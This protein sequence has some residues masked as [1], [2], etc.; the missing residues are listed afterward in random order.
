MISLRLLHAAEFAQLLPA[1]LSP[2]DVVLQQLDRRRRLFRPL[3]PRNDLLQFLG[4]LVQRRRRSGGL[5]IRSLRVFLLVP[6]LNLA[7][8]EGELFLR[9]VTILEL[10]AAVGERHVLRRWLDVLVVDV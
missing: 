6:F 4:Q 9:D 8:N 7:F 5:F 3:Y 1:I 10:P 2:L